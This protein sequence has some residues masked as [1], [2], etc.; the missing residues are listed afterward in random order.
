MRQIFEN[1]D[2]SAE[3]KLDIGSEIIIQWLPPF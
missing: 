2:F 1:G 3:I